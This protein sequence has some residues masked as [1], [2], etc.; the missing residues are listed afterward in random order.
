MII[1]TDD[2][3]AWAEGHPAVEA[4]CRSASKHSLAL[5]DIETPL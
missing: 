4:S 3:F 1:A 5:P 2:L